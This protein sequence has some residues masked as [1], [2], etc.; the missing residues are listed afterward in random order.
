MET[1]TFNQNRLSRIAVHSCFQWAA[2][3]L[4]QTCRSG[5]NTWGQRLSPTPPECGPG[6]PGAE[7]EE[8]LI[9]DPQASHPLDPRAQTDAS[10]Y[11]VRR[12]FRYGGYSAFDKKTAAASACLS[13]GGGAWGTSVCKSAA[14]AQPND[15]AG[16]GGGGRRRRP[17]LWRRGW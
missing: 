13:V 5:A 8:G 14:P 10:D 6:A 15:V 17:P 11:A 2:A 16:G 7:R 4:T 1:D 3:S 12:T 9:F